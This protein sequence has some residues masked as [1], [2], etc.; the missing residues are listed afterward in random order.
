MGMCVCVCVCVCGGGGVVR[1]WGG[2]YGWSGAQGCVYG[3]GGWRMGE[4]DKAVCARLCAV[5]DEHG[6]AR[7]HGGAYMGP[8]THAWD[9][10]GMTHIIA[11]RH[12]P[13]SCLM[14][15]GGGLGMV[16]TWMLCR[17]CG[18]GATGCGPPG[19]MGITTP[20]LFWGCSNKTYMQYVCH[21]A[22]ELTRCCGN[23]PQ[24]WASH[25]AWGLNVIFPHCNT[26]MDTQTVAPHPPPT[27]CFA[28][29]TLKM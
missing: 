17:L 23:K 6:G 26:E 21:G 7:V 8:D 13:P 22:L 27:F 10:S 19:P 5:C 4:G 25:A 16:F 20:G 1:G 28:S 11:H 12:L 18:V 24:A 29:E 14:W 3:N 2:M 15:M 9:D